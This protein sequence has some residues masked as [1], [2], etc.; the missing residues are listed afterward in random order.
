MIA[1][2]ATIVVPA[3]LLQS[4]QS[5]VEELQAALQDAQRGRIS[6]AQDVQDLQ[7][8]NVALKRELKANSE[9]IDLIRS[10]SPAT[11]A[12]RMD[13]AFEAIDEIDCRLARVERRPQ[14][15]PGGKTAARLTQ[16]KEILRQRGS[17]TFAELRR[18][19]DLAPSELTRLLQVADHRSI[20]IFYRP[21]DHRQKVIRLKAQI[22]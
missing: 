6:T 2:S 10:A 18:S 17:L 4:L 14:T 8:Q 7:A 9:A 1:D 20:E 21:G 3:D 12:L 15:V 16:M 5:Q 13:D 22:R 11:T 19:M